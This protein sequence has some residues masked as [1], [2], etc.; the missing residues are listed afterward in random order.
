M[1]VLCEKAPFKSLN[2]CS[3]QGSQSLVYA[4]SNWALLHCDKAIQYS[5]NSVAALF[6]AG[7]KHDC[8]FCWSDAIAEPGEQWCM[9]VGYTFILN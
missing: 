5:Y 6:M 9:A 2:P 7:F 8:F 1:L 4:S 3:N